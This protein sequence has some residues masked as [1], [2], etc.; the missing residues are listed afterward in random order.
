MSCCFDVFLREGGRCSSGRAGG[1]PSSARL[2]GFAALLPPYTLHR[3]V[4][5]LG[6]ARVATL[7]FS[8]TAFGFSPTYVSFVG[9]VE[10][11]EAQRACAITLGFSRA[12]FGF[13]PTYTAASSVGVAR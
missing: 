8:R 2:A 1:N 7:G 12:T 13:S 10:R 6:W 4:R 11:S 9:W 5:K 3:Y